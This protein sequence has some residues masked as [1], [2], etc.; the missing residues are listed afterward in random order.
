[1]MKS[2]PCFRCCNSDRAPEG[3]GNRKD[4]SDRVGYCEAWNGLGGALAQHEEGDRIDA[5]GRLKTDK[6]KNEAGVECFYQK[7][8]V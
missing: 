7:A 6:Y 1:M 4:S 8:V 2:C 5:S 3:A